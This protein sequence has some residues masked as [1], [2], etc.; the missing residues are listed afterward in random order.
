VR[1]P[2]SSPGSIPIRAAPDRPRSRFRFPLS[3][4]RF[5]FFSFQF[6]AFLSLSL[7]RAPTVWVHERCTNV[8]AP[9]DG[10]CFTLTGRWRWCWV[11]IRE[12]C[13]IDTHRARP[14]SE[15]SRLVIHIL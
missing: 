10:M 1:P 4:S 9:A 11:L 5:P 3:L 14:L 2:R 13:P 8:L 7:S 12:W 6:S 15:F